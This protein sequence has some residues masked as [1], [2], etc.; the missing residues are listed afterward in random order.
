M[1]GVS[2]DEL[3]QANPG[4]FIWPVRVYYED[5]DGGGV[6][7]HAN[8]LKF[9]ERARTEWLRHLGFEQTELKTHFGILFVVRKL[10]IQYK[11]PACFD[12]AIHV[13]STVAKIQRC[14]FTF[15]QTIKRNDEILTKALVEVVCVDA[16]A[17]S[18]ASIPESIRNV[19]AME[20][21]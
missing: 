19:I 8:Y 17:F 14:L 12:D 4:E 21:A 11:K 2:T 13:V 6:V 7:Y 15:E 5:T 20:S 16:E 1:A 18:P 10:E 3:P 9:M